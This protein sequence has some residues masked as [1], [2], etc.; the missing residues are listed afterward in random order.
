MKRIAIAAVL[1]LLAGFASAD[2]GKNKVVSFDAGQ[3]LFAGAVL[4]SSLYIFSYEM[5]M[6]MGA[7]Q[8]NALRFTLYTGTL[9]PYYCWDYTTVGVEMRNYNGAYSNSSYFSYDAV[10]GYYERDGFV[11][12]VNVGL[13]YAVTFGDS[14]VID[15]YF[16]AGTGGLA[17]G[18]NAGVRF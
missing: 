12:G 17:F 16:K 1:S 4:D 13:G 14:F 3:A 18:L 7:A 6:T 9:C 10:A 2:D 15:P 5:P 11:A 8:S